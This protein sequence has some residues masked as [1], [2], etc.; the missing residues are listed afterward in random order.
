MYIGDCYNH[1]VRKITAGVITT[2]A[3]T[4]TAGYSG[5]AGQAT[6][7]AISFPSGVNLDSHSNV[8]FGDS[9]NNVIREITVLTGM[10]T[11]VAGTGTAGYNGDNMQATAATLY[12]PY[13]VAL[14]SYGNLYI[15]DRNNYRIR[16]V[17]VST[18]VIATVVGTG[19]SSSTG[20]GAAA[21]SATIKGACANRFDSAG[22]LYIS[23]CG[24]FG[25]DDGNRIRKVVTVTTEIPTITPSVIPR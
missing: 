22:N 16:K 4:G 1:R 11:T 15:A 7:A 14:D 8:Y 3:G 23:E 9:G 5:D 6:A 18:G 19:I 25:V 2:I 10:I 20:D 12:L 24:A 21:T 13:D 17:D